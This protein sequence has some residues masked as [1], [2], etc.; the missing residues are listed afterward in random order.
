MTGTVVPFPALTTGSWTD[1]ERAALAQLWRSYKRFPG[2]SAR[3]D[4]ATEQGDPVCSF[5]KDGGIARITIAKCAGAYVVTASAGCKGTA[6][7]RGRSMD[8]LCAALLSAA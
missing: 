4:Y 3:V 5:L 8:E 7:Y 6:V 2:F 1:S